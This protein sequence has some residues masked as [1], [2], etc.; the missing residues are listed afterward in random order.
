MKG[1]TKTEFSL[2]RVRRHR[3]ISCFARW[4]WDWKWWR[5]RDYD[6]RSWKRYRRTQWRTP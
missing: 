5:P 1:G 3:F 2:G 6:R 4:D